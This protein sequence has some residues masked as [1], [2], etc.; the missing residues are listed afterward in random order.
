MVRAADARRSVSEIA[1]FAFDEAEKILEII[2]PCFRVRHDE[3]GLSRD[4]RDGQNIHP[5]FVGGIFVEQWR[6]GK[7]GPIRDNE[8]MPILRRAL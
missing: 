5:G 7:H 8:R 2:D 6:D 4:E 3:K 1:R